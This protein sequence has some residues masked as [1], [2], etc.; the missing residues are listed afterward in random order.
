[1]CVF[2]QFF[3]EGARPLARVSDLK[4]VFCSENEGI[5]MY[6]W[7][8]IYLLQ[9]RSFGGH[10][11]LPVYSTCRYHE[12]VRVC[13]SDSEPRNPMLHTRVAKVDCM[14]WLASSFMWAG[15]PTQWV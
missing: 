8:I 9:C 6:A 12:R 11:A 15:M 4:L 2:R 3:S 5:I 14:F 13:V 7:H 10:L 1:M